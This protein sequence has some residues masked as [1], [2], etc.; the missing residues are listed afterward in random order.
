MAP[1]RL[2]LIVL[3]AAL[4]GLPR[5]SGASA[6]GG[7]EIRFVPPGPGTVS[8]GIHDAQGKLVRILCDE[9]T[10]SRFHI[11][12]NGL[13]TSWDRKDDAGQP[14]PPGRYEARGYVVG[15]V[16]VAG[17][18]FHFNDW[19]ETE[20]SPRIVRVAAQQLLP[21]GD[22]LLAARLAG[23]TGALVRYSP[24]SEARWRTVVSAPRPQPASSAQLAVS[25]DTAFVLLDGSLRALKLEDGSEVTV[26]EPRE[27]IA[28]V[29]ARGDR[30]GVVRGDRLSLFR[31]PGFT[32][33]GAEEKTPAP[34]VSIA[35]L[36]KGMVAAAADGSLWSRGSGWTKLETPAPVRGVAAGR[37]DTFWVLEER[38]D[39]SWAVAQC[40]AEEGRLA[41]WIPARADGTPSALSAATASDH[42]AVTLVAP[43]I[44]RTVAIRRAATGGWE[45]AVDKKITRSDAFGWQDGKLA[46]SGGTLPQEITIKLDP[47]ELDP[48]A[49]G[50]LIL[51]AVAGASGTGLAT[52]EGL[53]LIGVTESADATRVMVVPGAAPGEAR[54]FQGDGACV[55]EYALSQ[56]GRISSFDAGTIELASGGEVP[57]PPAEDGPE[58]PV[59]EPDTSTSP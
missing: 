11:G 14:V 58:L 9:W 55:E 17:E 43:D 34:F 33:E 29:A 2:I 27:G 37:G 35:L 19:I 38:P 40:D 51:K 5:A 59:Q 57:P 54:F 18:A 30:I 12:L 10:F 41:E 49:P 52:T 28:A 50:E 8:L 53:P 23:G 39:G 25:D 15:D 6:D 1:L 4:S 48:T 44:Q 24:E 36:D 31:L 20:D 45:I 3:L 16:D 46:A 32:A 26:P 22:M 7:V 21:G 47:N 42:F 56:L 13:A